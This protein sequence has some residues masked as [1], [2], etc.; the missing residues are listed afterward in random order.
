MPFAKVMVAFVTVC[1]PELFHAD[2]DRRRVELLAEGH[3]RRV[4]GSAFLAV[5]PFARA[6]A[7]GAGLRRSEREDGTRRAPWV[8]WA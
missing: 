4:A 1:I 2:T 5:P 7:V 8:A 6:M 3:R